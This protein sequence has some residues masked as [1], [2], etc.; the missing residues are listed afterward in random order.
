MMCAFDSSVS[1]KSAYPLLSRIGDALVGL[2]ERAYVD[3]LATPEM[4]VYGPVEGKLQR[5]PV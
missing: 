5:P 3:G 1:R 2:K 4:P